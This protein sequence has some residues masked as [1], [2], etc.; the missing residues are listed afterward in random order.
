[1]V[2]ASGF[3]IAIEAAVGPVFGLG[4]ASV[5]DPRSYRLEAHCA[6]YPERAVSLDIEGQ[7]LWNGDCCHE[8]SLVPK[9]TQT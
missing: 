9:H 3:A 8:G 6:H 5:E 4:C 1:M 2:A 7:N